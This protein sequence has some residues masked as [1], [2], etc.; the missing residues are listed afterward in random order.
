[1][2]EITTDKFRLEKFYTALRTSEGLNPLEFF[3]DRELKE[4]GKLGEKWKR[5]GYISTLGPRMTLTSKGYLMMDS[6]ME[7]V[8]SNIKTL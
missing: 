4:W 8:F 1:M 5:S 2:E 3:G 6:L 7:D